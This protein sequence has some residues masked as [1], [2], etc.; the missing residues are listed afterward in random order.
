[1][2]FLTLRLE[3][4]DDTACLNSKQIERAVFDMGEP[5]GLTF[6]I[7]KN[8]D[9][10]YVQAAGFDDRYRIEI[11]D[12][13]GEGF[14]HWLAGSPTR[15][16]RSDV[17]MRYRNQC[18]IHGHRSC[19]LPAWGENVLTLADVLPILLFY[20]AAGGRLSTY[21]WE[22]VSEYFLKDDLKCIKNIRPK[23]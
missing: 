9:G 18:D 4:H 17:V 3:G 2:P 21:P 11:R 8:Q 1:M 22:D 20:H 5:D 16:D 7:L 19:P 12:V 14:R 10:G 15:K 6:V 13:Y 23:K